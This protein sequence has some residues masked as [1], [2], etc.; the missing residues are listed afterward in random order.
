MS[1]PYSQEETDVQ[2]ML[3]TIGSHMPESELKGSI[4]PGAAGMTTGPEGHTHTHRSVTPQQTPLPNILHS[5]NGSVHV[6][7]FMV[8]RDVQG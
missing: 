8:T 4:T 2:N 6:V 7:I 5:S 1:C 3:I